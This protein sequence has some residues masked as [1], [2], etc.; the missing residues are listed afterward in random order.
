MFDPD[1]IAARERQLTTKL[2]DALPG[3]RLP[4]RSLDECHHYQRSLVKAVDRKGALTRPLTDAERFFLETEQL[5]ATLDYRYWLERYAIIAKE[6]QEAA[7]LTPLWAS[8]ELFLRHLAQMESQR[9][10]GGHPDGILVNVLKARQLG[11]STITET[12]VAHRLT[13]QGT[14]RALIAADVQAQA[15]YMFS[16]AE[17]VVANL[18]WWLKPAIRAHQTGKVLEFETGST[19][20]V[21]YGKSSRGG[22]QDNAKTK[23]NIGRGRTYGCL[24]LS[25]LSSWERPEQIDDALLP[26]VPRRSRTFGVFESTAKGR[27][28]WWHHQWLATARGK[29]RFRNIFIPWYIEPDKYWSPAPLDWEPDPHTQAHAEAVLADSPQYLFGRTVRLS[30]DQLYWYESTKASYEEKGDLYKF[31]EE[32]PANDR[33]AFQYAGRS[34]FSSQTLERLKLYEKPPI[35]VAYVEPAREIAQLKAWERDREKQAAAGTA[36]IAPE[37]M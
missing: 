27:Y 33:E 22:L 25:E 31:Y 3:G 26:G 32:Y 17:L 12:I 4:R 9:Y 19:A 5:L 21:E 34:I 2:G 20:K 23:G 37:E 35:V 10:F 1:V 8:Q 15:E 7:P 24:H 14:L 18:P 29:T 6:T 28:D 13:V 16:M 11:I 30:K 36:S